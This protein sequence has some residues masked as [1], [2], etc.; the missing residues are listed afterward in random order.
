M[1]FFIVRCK[2]NYK[3]CEWSLYQHGSN[4]LFFILE[5]NKKNT[6]YDYV[7]YNKTTILM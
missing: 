4:N 6:D 3:L 1:S 5:K 7:K 2:N